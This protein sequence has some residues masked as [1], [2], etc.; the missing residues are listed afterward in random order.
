LY[1]PEK[2]NLQKSYILKS[3][4]TEEMSILREE[5]FA[6]FNLADEQFSDKSFA[7]FDPLFSEK[8][9]QSNFFCKNFFP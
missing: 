2:G 8:E 5:I 3:E 6:E 1:C 4:E 7:H 9:K